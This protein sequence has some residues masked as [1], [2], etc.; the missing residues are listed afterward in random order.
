METQLAVKFGLAVN[1]IGDAGIKALSQG[2]AG[3]MMANIEQLVLILNN[4]GDDGFKEFAA[5][6]AS[7]SFWLLA[8]SLSLSLTRKGVGS[9]ATRTRTPLSQ[10]LRSI[11][12]SS[13]QPA[14][15]F[16]FEFLERSAQRK[17]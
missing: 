7:P 5:A 3:G 4:Y 17:S 11:V 13:L 10:S 9:P 16:Y 6:I 14:D 15:N 1:Q 8:V 2:I 12:E